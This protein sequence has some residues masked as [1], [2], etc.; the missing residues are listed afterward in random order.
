MKKTLFVSFSGGRTSGRMCHW[1]IE[2]KSD[3]Y[4]FIFVFAN[5]GQE[6]ER[7]LEFVNTCDIKFGLNLI[8][9]E[10][11][12]HHD[13]R[14]GCT[15]KIVDFNTANRDGSVFEDMIKKYGIPNQAWPHCN[16]ELKLNPIFSL[17]RELGFKTNHPMAVGYRADEMDRIGPKAK[18]YNLV[19][20][21]V[22][23]HPI[24]K[25][26]VRHWWKEQSFDLELDEHE[27]NCMTC[28]KK[29]DRKLLTVA[30]QHPER[31]DFFER[32]EK[33]HATAGHGA[34]SRVFF[35]TNKSAIDMVARSKKPF[36]MFVDYM[37]ELQ[38]GFGF[39]VDIDP[40]DREESCGQG[41]EVG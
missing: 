21:L 28:W 33:A 14:D 26:E 22:F 5:T 32:M 9:I 8:W 25:E 7:T 2:N 1:L 6:D 27:G 30:K 10:A 12:T 4:D 37:P 39:G 24:T 16:R 34:E 23:W 41:C 15:H 11:V 17:K 35:R 31:F 3:E 29:S 20:P 18:E 19:F 40:L 36:K 13:S 38:L